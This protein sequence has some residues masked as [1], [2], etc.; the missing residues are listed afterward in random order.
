MMTTFYTAL[1]LGAVVFLV[2]ATG[3]RLAGPHTGGHCEPDRTDLATSR[4]RARVMRTARPDDGPASAPPQGA[5]PGDAETT[6]LPASSGGLPDHYRVRYAG[7]GVVRVTDHEVT[8]ATLAERG[9]LDA[10]RAD[11]TAVPDATI[12]WPYE[13]HWGTAAG[14]IVINGPIE[15]R[16]GER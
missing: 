14:H 3:I 12:A 15:F 1:I 16:D 13:R 9:E 5:G 8:L 2:T 6:V 10:T 11:L 4:L 7:D